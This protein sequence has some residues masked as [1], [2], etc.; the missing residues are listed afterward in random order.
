MFSQFSDLLDQLYFTNKTRQ[1]EKILADFFAAVPDPERGY[2][3]ASL[4]GVLRLPGYRRA[5]VK[6]WLLHAWIRL[7]LL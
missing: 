4:V 2:A 7:Y 5:R 3:L 6:A 1:K